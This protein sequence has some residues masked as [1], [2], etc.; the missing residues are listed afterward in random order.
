MIPCFLSKKKKKEELND[1]LEE[2]SFTRHIF[3]AILN[4]FYKK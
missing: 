4:F 1:M 2:E 3:L